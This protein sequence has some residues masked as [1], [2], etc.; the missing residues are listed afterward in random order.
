MPLARNRVLEFVS[1]MEACSPGFDLIELERLAGGDAATLCG[2]LRSLL[3]VNR[4]DL[5]QLRKCLANRDVRGLSSLAHRVKGAVRLVRAQSVI[6]ACQQLEDGCARSACVTAEI[7][8]FL[9]NLMLA[10]LHLEVRL[11]RHRLRHHWQ[12]RRAGRGA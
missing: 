12:H 3:Q 2:L 5:Q 6:E 11:R 8:I 9:Q 1:P 4:E 10:M 7:V